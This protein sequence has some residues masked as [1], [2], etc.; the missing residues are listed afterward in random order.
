[1]EE[2]ALKIDYIPV[3]KNPVLVVGF[4]G[5]GN[6][7]DISRGVVDYIARK[8]EAKP[9][10]KINPDL[11]YR[12]DEN[13]PIVEIENGI[14]KKITPPDCIFYAI[15]IH[16]GDQDLVLLKGNEPNLRWFQFTEAVLSLCLQ[17]GV[18]LIVSLGSMYDNVLHTDKIFS[19]VATSKDLLMKIKQT[20]VR[21]IGYRGPGAIHSTLQDEARKQ[22]L[23][24]VSIW[25]H[26]PYYLQGTTHFGL[27]S[28]LGSLLSSFLG[29]TLDVKELEIAWEDLSKQI[30]GIVEKNPELQGVIEELKKAKLKGSWNLAKKDEKVIHLKDFLETK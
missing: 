10:A 5:W 1:M 4:E 2:T 9:F 28:H 15:E 17:L 12:F 8:L 29:F 7:L 16:Q 25:C 26:C 6:A 22:N 18:K 23:E 11:F 21:E 13:R 3:L 27:L 14:L 20:N 24:C 19:A 30:Q